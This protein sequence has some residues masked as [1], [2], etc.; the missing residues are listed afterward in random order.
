MVL[1]TGKEHDKGGQHAV[2]GDG[3]REP[4]AVAAVGLV[5]GAAV[6]EGED[7]VEHGE[8]VKHLEREEE[9]PVEGDGA[10]TDDD[11]GAKGEEEAL[12]EGGVEVHAGEA[13]EDHG[14]GGEGVEEFGD[15]GGVGVVVFAPVY[16]VIREFEKGEMSRS[17]T[18]F[19]TRT[20]IPLPM[21]K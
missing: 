15:V 18:L 7:R 13:D 2:E 11:D 16:D 3:D 6:E 20:R 10:D 5:L 4:D 17:V 14:E 12:L 8:L 19:G 1:G 9:R 21:W